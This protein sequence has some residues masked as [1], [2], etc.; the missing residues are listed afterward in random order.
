MPI[1]STVLGPMYVEDSGTTNAQTALLWPSLFTD[2]SMWDRQVSALR[3]TGWRTLALDPPG[4]GRSVGPGRSFTMDECADAVVQIL[5]AMEVRQSVVML[6]TS[7]G[8]MIGPRVALRTPERI[9]R[10]V[11]FNTTAECPTPLTRANAILLTWMLGIKA[12]DQIVNG[13]LLSS[14]LAPETRR[15]IPNIGL[16]LIKKLRSW[17]RQ[18]VISSVR[19]VLVDRDATLDALSKIRAPAL[20]ISGAEDKILPSVFSQRIVE[21]LPGSRHVEVPGAAHLVPVEAAEA[22]NK[23]ILDFVLQPAT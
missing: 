12:L 19:S 17:D 20:L 21:R 9:S 3:G 6:G 4:H 11:L 7:W 2:H 18:R 16:D 1:I 8:G 14:I 13:I 23:L 15:H 10:M 22:A 5:D